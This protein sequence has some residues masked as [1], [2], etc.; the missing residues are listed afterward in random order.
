MQRMKDQALVGLGWELGDAP[1]RKTTSESPKPTGIS[2][3]KD[4]RRKFRRSEAVF[5]RWART[6]A[7][8]S[9]YGV[10]L[11]ERS[12]VNPAVDARRS[13]SARG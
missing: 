11:R 2:V 12:S 13:Q 9:T 7:K 10:I 3:S 4:R 5:Y 6:K 8:A 1:R